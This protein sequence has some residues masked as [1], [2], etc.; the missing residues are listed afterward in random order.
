MTKIAEY[1]DLANLEYIRDN[2]WR[3]SEY[4][5]VSIM[6]GA[7][8]SR[9]AEKKSPQTPDFP[10]WNDIGRMIYYELYPEKKKNYLNH[11]GEIDRI[12]FAQKASD[13]ASDYEK[14]FGRSALNSLLI[15]IIPDEYYSPGKLHEKLLSLPWSDI[16]TTNYDTLLERSLPKIYGRKYDIITY[17]TQIPMKFKPRIIK[18][19]GNIS[20]NSFIITNE[21]YEKYPDY[22]APFQ[23]LVQES[24][25]ENIL[26]LIGFSGTD[27]NFKRWIT[28]VH[29]NLKKHSPPVFL[30]GILDLG[31]SDRQKLEDQK[32]RIIDLAPLFPK[33]KFLNNII[34]YRVAL[35]WLLNS[36]QNG[37][38]YNKLHWPRPDLNQIIEPMSELAPIILPKPPNLPEM[39]SIHPKKEEIKPEMVQEVTNLWSQQR[40]LYPGWMLAPESAR[41]AIWNY[42]QHWIRPILS[43]LKECNPQER[44]FSLYELNWRLEISLIPLFENIAIEIDMILKS[45]NPFPNFLGLNGIDVTPLNDEYKDYDWTAISKEWVDLAFSLC[46]YS[47]E[48]FKVDLYSYWMEIIQK[49]IIIDKEWEM[50]Y[51]FE[52][53]LFN[54]FSFNQEILNQRLKEWPTEI[55]HPIYSMKKASIMAELGDTDTAEQL[56]KKTLSEIRSRI[57]SSQDDF[58]LFSQEGWC[59]LLLDFIHKSTIRPPN[60]NFAD[61]K[62]RWEQLA[63]FHCDPW[64]ELDRLQAKINVPKPEIRPIFEITSGFDPGS[65]RDTF[66]FS[67]KTIIEKTLQ[68]FSFLKMYENVGLPMSCNQMNIFP[69]E[70]AN[71]SSWIEPYCP[72]WAIN[73]VIRSNNE[74]EIKEKFNRIQISNLSQET[75]ERYYSISVKSLNESIDQLNA[76][77]PLLKGKV[78]FSRKQLII[79]SE[80]LSRLSIRLNP[81]QLNELL[82]TAIKM[83]N[84]PI[85][86]SSL[87]FYDGI[88]NLFS[89]I[90]Y[91][92]PDSYILSNMSDLLAL[93]TPGVCDIPKGYS[94]HLSEPFGFIEWKSIPLLPSGYDRT[95]WTI[96]LVNLFHNAKNGEPECRKRSLMRLFKIFQIGGLTEDEKRLFSDALWA[97]IN[98]TTK[99]PESTYFFNSTFLQLPEPEQGIVKERFRSWLINQPIP[100]VVLERD[101]NKF[102]T[103]GSTSLDNYVNEWINASLPLIDYNGEVNLDHY[104]DW[105]SSE[106]EVLFNKIQTVWEKKKN[107]N[108][109]IKDPTLLH[110]LSREFLIL[111]SLFEFVI[112][113]RLDKLENKTTQENIFSIL[114][115]LEENGIST[116]HLKIFKILICPEKIEEINYNL[117]EGFYS[118]DEII[119][120]NSNKGFYYWI[121]LE[122]E[123]DAMKVPE[124]LS[125]TFIQQIITRKKPHLSSS[126][127]FAG[128]ISRK[129]PNYF[130]EKQNGKLIFG[131][132]KIYQDIYAEFPRKIMPGSATPVISSDELLNIKIYSINLA[133]YIEIICNTTG[134]SVPDIIIKWKR[135]CET[136]PLPEIRM[137]WELF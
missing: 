52:N 73:S 56:L 114:H 118:S 79:Q 16:F 100:S 74:A 29:D 9:N 43:N 110:Y 63:R 131:L 18:L 102:S 24:I 13:Y 51:Y 8:F 54:L 88:N 5:K 91:A 12:D 127:M 64:V 33:S 40:K 57:Q 2:L 93:Y 109:I 72:I 10:L 26:C 133:K 78:S 71:A 116:H 97:K 3:G 120:K 87:D 11:E 62:D 20:E 36:L 128:Q 61:Y 53:C 122:N 32:I 84:S 132:E 39:G 4:G 117:V 23:N 19:H 22:Y 45:I 58:S 76:E 30:I 38:P 28:W 67:G 49:L 35:D 60:I 83:Y 89:R 1:R 70:I 99:L 37:K 95:T 98:P 31:E 48:H 104:I 7:G 81:D 68:G 34:R 129:Y 92:I 130:S 85:L 106:I 135:V 14:K 119:V 111:T 108:K 137:I 105:T 47:R 96:K 101:N 103:H 86:N 66:H 75:I 123:R 107:W 55:V 59:M 42:T 90:F 124:N 94:S 125:E 113:Q 27:P 6:V 15:K 69:E 134:K 126:L 115:E 46:R 82:K 41:D 121:I 77:N 136:D 112:L 65:R 44:I 50:R 25:I 80:F 17:T 21:D